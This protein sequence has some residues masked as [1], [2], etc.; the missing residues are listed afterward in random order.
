MIA[1]YIYYDCRIYLLWLQNIFIMIAE[2]TYYDCRIYL[3]WL[4]N[5]HFPHN[6]YKKLSE[7]DTKIS[8]YPV[9]LLPGQFQENYTR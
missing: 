4:Q 7:E 5:I 6:K 9:S 8:A 2:Y 1:E 3:L